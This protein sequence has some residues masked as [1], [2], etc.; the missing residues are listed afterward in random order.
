MWQLP[1]PEQQPA[2]QLVASQMQVPLL[3]RRPVLH[4]LFAPHRQLPEELQVSALVESHATQAPPVTPQVAKADVTQPVAVQHPVGHEVASQLTQVPATHVWPV[5]Q[6]GFAP[7][8][9]PPVAQPS[10]SVVLHA[11]HGAA[12]MPQ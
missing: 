9:Q 2:G 7:Q 4:W 12:P 11:V 10:A 1:P 3:Q 6:A 5:T 8:V